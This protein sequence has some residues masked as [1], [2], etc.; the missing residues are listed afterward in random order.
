MV[1][2]APT[3]VVVAAAVVSVEPSPLFSVCRYLG[4]IADDRGGR[5]C[6]CYCYCFYRYCSGFGLQSG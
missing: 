5:Y 1:T 4:R 2:V 3:V 6:N